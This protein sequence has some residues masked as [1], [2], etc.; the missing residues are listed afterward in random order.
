MALA[1]EKLYQ[2]TP[3]DRGGYGLIVPY[4]RT[5]SVTASAT[6]GTATIAI[7]DIG[8]RFL[9]MQ[10]ALAESLAAGATYA[11]DSLL[12]LLSPTS[13]ATP[14][15]FYLHGSDIAGTVNVNTTRRSSWQG[16][17]LVPP[18]WQVRG[19][20]TYSAA[21]ANITRLSIAGVLIPRGSIQRL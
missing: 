13:D 2:L 12:A 9:L 16:S 3:G 20:A 1:F 8:D 21:T 11:E 15:V 6:T 19:T 18:N 7:T 14:G 5:V 17:V 10:S 4:F